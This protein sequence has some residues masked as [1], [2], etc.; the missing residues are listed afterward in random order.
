[1]L[2]VKLSNINPQE[3]SNN[4]E[5]IQGANFIY[6]GDLQKPTSKNEIQERR[7]EFPTKKQ[8]IK[9]LPFGDKNLPEDIDSINPI[10][11]KKTNNKYI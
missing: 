3:A 1:M 7:K 5:S 9:A 6:T 2:T 10:K 8:L 11:G 4:S